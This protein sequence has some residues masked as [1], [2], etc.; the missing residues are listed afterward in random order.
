MQPVQ[1]EVCTPKPRRQC[2]DW[3]RT[4]CDSR[5]GNVVKE[6]TWQNQRLDP[7]DSENKTK[8]ETIKRCN[9][10]TV[11]EVVEQEVPRQECKEVKETRPVCG[12]MPVT[13]YKVW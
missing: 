2:F 13:K 1:Q 8:C 10:T 3:S 4:V 9:Y 12:R 11:D 6:V 7:V 5:P